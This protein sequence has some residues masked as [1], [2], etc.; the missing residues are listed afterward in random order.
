MKK[1]FEYVLMLFTY[2][3]VSL[4]TTQQVHIVTKGC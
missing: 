2:M 1:I 4:L 3:S